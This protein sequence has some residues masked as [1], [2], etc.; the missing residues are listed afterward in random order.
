MTATNRKQTLHLSFGDNN[1][2]ADIVGPHDK[3]L[4]H[5]EERLGV[6]ISMRG[7]DFAISGAETDVQSAKVVL[8]E[9]YETHDVSSPTNMA[10]V[11]MALKLATSA[12]YDPTQDVAGE[13]VATQKK[14][15]VPHTPT[16][17]KYIQAI[18]AK[19]LVFGIGPAGTGKTYLAVAVGV[20]RLLSG[21]VNR[22]ILSRPAVE[23]GEKLGFLPGD[24]REKIDPYLRP[25]YDAM[26]DMLPGDQVIK[27]LSNGEIEVAPLAFMRGRTL[28]DAF[29]VLD[30]AQNTT[31]VQMKMFLTRLGNN[32]QMVITGDMSQV[33]LPPGQESGLRVALD[34][35]SDIDEIGAVMF[36][37]KDVVRHPLVA[38][39][40]AAYNEKEG[41][42]RPQK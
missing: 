25:L 34:T 42:D 4:L 17:A 27:R 21:E 3:Y 11:E 28:S 41:A 13:T 6:T 16:Q 24:M 37:E 15:V 30:E 19:N 38:K 10:K 18:R 31:P 39:I 29:V 23:A 32:S 40:V 2:L 26:H 14:I 12:D 36:S 1:A 5:I 9:L 22:I 33:D 35:L 7:N 8:E 20:T